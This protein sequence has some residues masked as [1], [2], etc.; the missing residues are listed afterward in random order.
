MC[1]FLFFII[2]IILLLPTVC[3]RSCYWRYFNIYQQVNSWL[4]HVFVGSG[5]NSQQISKINIEFCKWYL[6]KKLSFDKFISEISFCFVIIKHD[7]NSY[8]SIWLN[9]RNWFLY[10]DIMRIIAQINLWI[11]SNLE[12]WNLA[13]S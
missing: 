9:E 5:W 13:Y 1:E 6:L 2:I 11:S 7:Y 3:L 8:C 4:Q 10:V 12:L